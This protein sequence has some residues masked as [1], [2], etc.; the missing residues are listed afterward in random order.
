MDTPTRP[1]FAHGERMIGIETHL[2]RKVEGDGKAG[3]ALAQEIPVALVAL[4]RAAES[5]VLPHGPE[6]GTIHVP[7]NSAGVGISPGLS[8]V[9]MDSGAGDAAGLQKRRNAVYSTDGYEKT[10]DRK[11]NGAQI[12]GIAR[13]LPDRDDREKKENKAQNLVPQRVHRLDGGG[14][15][16]LDELPGLSRPDPFGPRI[17]PTK[18]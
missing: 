14:N 18:S 5:G 7:I 6:P 2:G 1:T 8:G 9:C 17:Y 4:F 12:G 16:M 11:L 13:H 10:E 15:D 3:S